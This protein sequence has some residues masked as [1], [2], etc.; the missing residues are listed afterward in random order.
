MTTFIDL[1]TEIT[2]CRGR[3]PDRGDSPLVLALH[4]LTGDE[5]SMGIFATH[6]P[7]P[8]AVIMPRG[9]FPSQ[10]GGFSWTR[11]IRKSFPPLDEFR[12][13]ADSLES[14]LQELLARHS[15]QPSG[16]HLIGF[17]QGAALSYALLIQTSW[18]IKSVAA[19]SGFLPSD[20]PP[21]GG[22]RQNLRLK[23]YIAHGARDE[24]V[25]VAA[26]REAV[27]T[28]EQTGADVGYCESDTSHKLGAA[29]LQNLHQFYKGLL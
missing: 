16:I 8:F 26:A 10:Y 13:A 15:I 11:S 7:S 21:I 27:T 4:G 28:L 29:C 5:N 22:E 12:D 19:L 18:E 24:R 2:K 14:L 9:I 1:G 17:S 23:V 3:L 20:F 6:I 25:P